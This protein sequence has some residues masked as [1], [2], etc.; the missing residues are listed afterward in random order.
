[1]L[2]WALI[3]F[4]VAIIAAVFGREQMRQLVHV[5]FNERLEVEQHARAAPW[6]GAAP[7]GENFERGLNGGV[8]IARR[9]ERHFSLLRAGVGIENAASAP[10]GSGRAF[11]IDIVR[12]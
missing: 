12:N 8:D 2:S 4:V 9:G 10:A 6:V 5:L 11:A 1:M 7:L 3:F